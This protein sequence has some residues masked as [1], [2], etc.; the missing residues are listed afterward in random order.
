M[1]AS[2]AETPA[3]ERASSTVGV[4]SCLSGA[5]SGELG[6]NGGE[7]GLHGDRI[8]RLHLLGQL[9]LGDRQRGA[10]GDIEGELEAQAQL[11]VLLEDL[12][13]DRAQDGTGGP[14]EDDQYGSP[15]QIRST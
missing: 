8:G 3:A 4:G 7:R 13:D 12:V 1:T 6:S 11:A 2:H 14:S 5:G 10:G 9:R 15:S